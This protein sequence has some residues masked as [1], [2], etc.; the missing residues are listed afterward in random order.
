[1]RESAE[2]AEFTVRLEPENAESRGN[3]RPL[4]LVVWGWNSFIGAVTFHGILSTGQLVRQHTADGFVENSVVKDQV[5]KK[6]DHG[7]LLRC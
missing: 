1:M 3:H 7:M 4:S 6:S 2:D 5:H